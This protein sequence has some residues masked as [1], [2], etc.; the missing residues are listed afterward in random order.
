MTTFDEVYAGVQQTIAAHAQAQDD[1]RTEE[2][3]ALYCSDGL[4][5][6]PGMGSYQGTEVLRETWEAWKPRQS[7]RHM[8]SNVVVTEWTDDTA[9]ARTDVVFFQKSGDGWNVGIVARYH[10]EFRRVA[11]AWLISQR[12]DEYIDWEPPAAS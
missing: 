3:V 7:Q 12:S 9:K 11:D 1:G 8:S 2:I 10:D 6:V 4:L 5:V